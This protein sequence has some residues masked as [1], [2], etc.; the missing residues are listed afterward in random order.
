MQKVKTLFLGS[1]KQPRTL[2][3]TVSRTHL[4]CWQQLRDPFLVFQQIQ[5]IS[6]KIGSHR[7]LG[8]YSDLNV[9][10]QIYLTSKLHGLT[11]YP[12]LP[13]ASAEVRTDLTA[14][15][16]MTM[17][18]PTGSTTSAVGCPGFVYCC[19]LVNTSK[20]WH[21]AHNTHYC[22]PSGDASELVNWPV[23]VNVT[24]I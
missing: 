22:A 3:S 4:P 8:N 11:D 13:R 20:S 15:P 2:T 7:I 10:K 5:T 24:Q 23:V 16:R 19:T 12:S 9:C 14:E 1:S 21:V 6:I 18:S 17:N